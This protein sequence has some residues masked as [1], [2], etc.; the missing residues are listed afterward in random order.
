M[1]ACLLSSL[2]TNEELLT[3]QLIM[4]FGALSMSMRVPTTASLRLT[5]PRAPLTRLS[6]TCSRPANLQTEFLQAQSSV[7]GLCA[8]MSGEE[9]EHCSY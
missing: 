6:L 4:S 9:A 5:A 8:S 3:A 1:S 7:R 2:Q